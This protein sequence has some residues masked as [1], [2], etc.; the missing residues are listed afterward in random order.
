MFMRKGDTPLASSILQKTSAL[1]QIY[2]VK[3]YWIDK[4]NQLAVK[5]LKLFYNNAILWL[6]IES[7]GKITDEIIFKSLFS[8][9]ES[10]IFLMKNILK[11]F[12]DTILPE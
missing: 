12:S 10:F 6:L 7:E 9:K 4:K 8:S 1:K 3:N 2:D 5:N 11:S